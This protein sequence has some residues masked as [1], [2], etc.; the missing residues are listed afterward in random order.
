MDSNKP[1]SAPYFN[2]ARDYWWHQE[3]LCL[4]ASRLEFEKVNSL[5]DVGA[6]QGH[7]GLLLL[8]LLSKDAKLVGIEPE[9]KWREIAYAR[10]ER[11]EI[12]N[13]VQFMEG[14]AEKLPF[15]DNTFDMVTCQTVLIHLANPLQALL[16][17]QR[18]LKPGGLLLAS[19]PNNLI[20]HALSDSLNHNDS[21]EEKTAWFQFQLTCDYGKLAL[22]EGNNLVGDLLPQLFKQAYL[23]EI[24]TYLADTADFYVPPYQSPRE[25]FNLKSFK[26]M[27]TKEIHVWDK[28]TTK[29]YYLAGGGKAPDF[30][31]KWK[32]IMGN[33][34]IFLQAVEEGRYFSQGG[35]M[36][37]LTSGRK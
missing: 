20:P 2:D 29:R 32:K 16:E 25:Q 36:H 23:K 8:P 30:E 5:L 37:Y 11:L 19:E 34:K 15:E 18:V 12:K 28:P 10:A 22:G 26:E 27:S 21:I 33:Q 9:D 17:M 7:W 35:I 13:S 14:S 4:M 31:E 1:H 6:G 3:F 24:Q